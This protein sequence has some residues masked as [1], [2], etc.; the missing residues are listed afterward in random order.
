MCSMLDSTAKRRA[1]RLIVVG[2]FNLPHMLWNN[3]NTSSDSNIES[4]VR[5]FAIEHDLTQLATQP[6]RDNALLDLVFVSPGL[7]D[8]C[9]IDNL[10]PIAGS[11]HST[12]LIHLPVMTK[13]DKD[14][15]E[16]TDYQLLG[17]ILSCVVWE[18]VFAACSTADDY[19]SIFT[20]TLREALRASSYHKP[21]YTRAALPRHIVQ[22]LRA[23][24]QEWRTAKLSGDFERFKKVSKTAQAAI[25]QHQRNQEHRLVSRNSRKAFFKHIYNKCNRHNSSITL[26]KDQIIMSD[27]DA[28]EAFQQEF[29]ANFSTTHYSVKTPI[30]TN[31]QLA[32]LNCNENLVRDA[33]ISCSGTSS[34]PDGISFKVLK[35]VA[36][37]I[38]RPLNIVFQHSFN[39][40][41]FP[42]V[43]KHAVVLPLFKGRGDRCAVSSYRPISLC[44]C[45]GKV[46]EKVV[47]VQ[48][49]KYLHDNDLL[50][51]AQHGFTAGRSTVTNMVHFDATVAAIHSQNHAY[52]IIALDYKKAFDRAPHSCVVDAVSSKGVVGKA[53]DWFT[54]YLQNRT[55]Q[56]RVGSSLS[57]LSNVASGVIQGSILGPVLYTVLTDEL[58]RMFSFPVDAFADDIKLLADV[59]V[60]SR[61]DVQA[62]V[63]RIVTWSDSHGMSLSLDKT[64]VMH[65]GYRQPSHDYYIGNTKLHAVDN[66]TDLGVRRTACGG[67]SGHSDALAAKAA[68]ISGAIRRAFRS[69]SRDL[70]WPAFTYYVLPVLMYLSQAWSPKLKRDIAVLEKVQRRFTKCIAGLDNLSYPERLRELNALTLSNR[71][72]Y[73]DM[74]FV[75]KCT[76]GLTNFSATDLGLIRV[77]STTR[78]NGCRLQ[79]RHAT[80]A[81]CNM[82]SIRAVHLWNNLPSH[83]VNAASIGTFKKTLYNYLLSV[84]AN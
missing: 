66:F 14:S 77:K 22:L 6:T 44:Q 34:S 9:V 31:S 33:I 81:T 37:Y 41:V 48:F 45:L 26:T 71:R 57:S 43:W 30:S 42:S 52:D 12:Q 21:R 28:A 39:D 13:Q 75:F 23:K 18:T 50:H 80:N 4:L 27:S 24:R 83:I 61:A 73:A 63:D 68:R 49:T 17:A 36:Q 84:Q 60:H 64:V 20:R 25:R 54:S 40:G 7:C 38:I 72:F 11:D 78:G 1:A 62:E 74:V 29:T 59:T 15:N 35:S 79:Q 2:D 5:R 51:H 55:Q 82:F 65:C 69:R 8:D 32:L 76:H 19:A 16:F 53:K 70:L 10:P 47:H 56:I 58:L 3:S 67:Y 46:L